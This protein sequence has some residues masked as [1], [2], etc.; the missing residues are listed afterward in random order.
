MTLN[1]H[2]SII[3][4]NLFQ[5]LLVSEPEGLFTQFVLLKKGE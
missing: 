3:K 5:Y 2:Y 4:F 1:K